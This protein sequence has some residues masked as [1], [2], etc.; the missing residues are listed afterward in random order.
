M[1]YL[2][3]MFLIVLIALILMFVLPMVKGNKNEIELGGTGT[4]LPN[5]PISAVFSRQ[6]IENPKNEPY[7]IDLR[8]GNQYSPLVL[9]RNTR[10]GNIVSTGEFKQWGLNQNDNLKDVYAKLPL[11]NLYY[12]KGANQS[13][14]REGLTNLRTGKT[15][16]F[17]T[18]FYD[19]V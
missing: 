12:I 2:L 10:F 17:P 19:P 16:P 8:T 6:S 4:D 3:F 5:I 9:E 18:K 14:V 1:N 11:E 13:V 7:H 15:I